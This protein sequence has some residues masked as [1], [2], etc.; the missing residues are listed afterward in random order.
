MARKALIFVE[1]GPVGGPLPTSV[2]TPH[3][4]LFILPGKH[5]KAQRRP[6]GP[7]FSSS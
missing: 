1:G 7:F 3:P 6:G 5:N 4:G 2:C